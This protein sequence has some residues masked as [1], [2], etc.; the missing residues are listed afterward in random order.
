MYLDCALIGAAYI[1]KE[2]IQFHMMHI[3][4]LGPGEAILDTLEA[5]EG[6][7]F[8]TLCPYSVRRE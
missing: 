7:T 4:P 1:S 3:Q 5:V 6:Q 2:K 8:R